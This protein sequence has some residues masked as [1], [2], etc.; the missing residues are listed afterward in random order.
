MLQLWIGSSSVIWQKR[1]QVNVSF[2]TIQYFNLQKKDVQ[3]KNLLFLCSWSLDDNQTCVAKQVI[4]GLSG[5]RKKNDSKALSP[6]EWSHA[7]YT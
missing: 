1:M 2:C 5:I 6:F 4:W 7:S 3:T